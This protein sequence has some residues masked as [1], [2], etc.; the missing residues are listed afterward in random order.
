MKNE[1]PETP[2]LHSNPFSPTRQILPDA[3]AAFFTLRST[4]ADYHP[5]NHKFCG[6]ICMND[7]DW[8]TALSP[9]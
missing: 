9:Y 8:L 5:E 4:N 7:M 1:K 3:F 2:L 6:G